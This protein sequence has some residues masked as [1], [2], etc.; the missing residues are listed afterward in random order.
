MPDYEA[1]PHGSGQQHCE[2]RAPYGVYGVSV[3]L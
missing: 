1:C 3:M 2:N